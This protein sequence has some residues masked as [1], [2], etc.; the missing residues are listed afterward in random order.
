VFALDDYFACEGDCDVVSS[1]SLNRHFN[2][3]IPPYRTTNVSVWIRDLL[4][5]ISNSNE[6]TLTFDALTGGFFGSVGVLFFDDKLSFPV[7]VGNDF[8]SGKKIR[9]HL[10]QK[11]VCVYINDNE[12]FCKDLQIGE[13][14][15]QGHIGFAS[16][17]SNGMSTRPSTVS[18]SNVTVRQNDAITDGTYKEGLNNGIAQCQNDPASCG[19][20]VLSES[21]TC[22]HIETHASFSLSDGIL[23][24]P[25][26]EVSNLSGGII[27]Y[28]AEM[29]LV[30]DEG[31]L[32][33][34][35]KTEPLQK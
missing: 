8:Y 19:I 14:P 2:V 31:L 26:V 27:T 35:T 11:R 10:T 30:P 22:P 24:I 33:S 16:L 21:G 15:K 32:F 6:I 18:Y 9:I 5:D 25:M 17:N 20:T 29:S 34:V 28:R 3:L 23:T 13:V 12:D 1:Y 4:Y 7:A